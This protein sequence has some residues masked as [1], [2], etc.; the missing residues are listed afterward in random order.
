LTVY[1]N[2]SVVLYT[3]SVNANYP[4][5]LAFLDFPVS[6]GNMSDLLQKMPNAYRAVMQQM[7]R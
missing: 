5:T 4:N 7:V 2:S 1:V 6:T 3:N